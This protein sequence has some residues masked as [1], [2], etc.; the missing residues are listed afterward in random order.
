MP[1]GASWKSQI[2]KYPHPCQT[3]VSDDN[4]TLD[5]EFP[6]MLVPVN[7]EHCRSKIYR[8]LMHRQK[9]ESYT[10]KYPAALKLLMTL[11]LTILAGVK[12]SDTRVLVSEV[13]SDARK[14]QSA[15]SNLLRLS[16]QIFELGE[17]YFCAFLLD[18]R[19]ERANAGIPHFPLK[20]TTMKTIEQRLGVSGR[21]KA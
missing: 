2:T 17:A 11:F 19:A 12:N 3:P 10:S 14:C 4:N 13:T 20:F 6:F 21:R 8:P 18:L 1:K 7:P 16:R 5:A 15:S 9:S